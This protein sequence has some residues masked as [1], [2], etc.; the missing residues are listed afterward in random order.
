MKQH[1]ILSFLLVL[2]WILNPAWDSQALTVSGHITDVSSGL[3]IS[4]HTVFILVDNSDNQGFNYYNRI[5]TDTNGLYSDTFFVP[6]GQAL[7]LTVLSFDCNM[8]P[9]QQTIQITQQQY[10]IDFQVCSGLSGCHAWFSSHSFHSNPLRITFRN[11]SLGDIDTYFWDFGDGTNSF[12]QQPIH[13]YPQPGTYIVSLTVS[14]S[15]PIPLCF[16]TFTDTIIVGNSPAPCEAKFSA[17]ANNT[18]PYKWHFQNQSTGII[19]Q[20]KWDFGDGIT[21]MGSNTMHVYSDTGLYNVCHIISGPQC[22]DTFCQTIHISSPG[23]YHL[24]GQ[25]FAGFF[26]A[27][28]AQVMLLRKID[29]KYMHER[30]SC[31]DSLG[32]YY[33]YHILGGQYILRAS[34]K[35]TSSQFGNY[36]PTYNPSSPFWYEAMEIHLQQNYFGANIQLKPYPVPAAG[37]GQISGLVVFGDTSGSMNPAPEVEVLLLNPGGQAV[38]ATWSLADGSFAFPSIQLGQYRIQAEV[39]GIPSQVAMVDLSPSQPVSENITLEVLPMMVLVVTEKA[40]T[41]ENSILMMPNPVHDEGLLVVDVARSGKIKLQV[42]GLDGKS[43]MDTILEHPGGKQ[44]YPIQMFGLPSGM[45]IIRASTDKDGVLSAKFL[46]LP[47]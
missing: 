22:Q 4:G 13:N 47:R 14:H 33:F 41:A 27:Q 18:N 23:Y 1:I 45:F 6:P 28:D 26:P 11:F 17:W 43:W 20:W 24:A 19:N 30:T 31:V 12:Q 3:G 36:I 44:R 37:P 10:A 2:F 29:G 16:S 5:K 46:K 21:S 25:V 42:L 40:F 38:G 8:I 7:T 15:N 34:P 39:P 9:Q 32:V 35:P